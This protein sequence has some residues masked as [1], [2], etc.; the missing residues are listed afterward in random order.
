[1]RSNV[2]YMNYFMLASDNFL[3]LK[4]H[5][6]DLMARDDFREVVVTTYILKVFSA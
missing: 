6:K 2:I 1:M 4:L 5:M 3:D